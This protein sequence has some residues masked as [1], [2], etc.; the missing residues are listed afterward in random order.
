MTFSASRPA[1][2]RATRSTV[3]TSAPGRP[4]PLPAALSR[5]SAHAARYSTSA[6][7]AASSSAMPVRAVSASVHLTQSSHTTGS[8][9][10]R[11]ASPASAA[12]CCGTVT[13]GAAPLGR[14]MG[15]AGDSLAVTV[16]STALTTGRR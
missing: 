15:T 13:M 2:A 11:D 9:S 5:F 3:N 12:A 7:R 16:V 14:A 4:A 1:V 10:T 8:T 6:S